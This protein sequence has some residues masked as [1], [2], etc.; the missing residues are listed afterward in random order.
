MFIIFNKLYLI[1]PISLLPRCFSPLIPTL[2]WELKVKLKV[3]YSRIPTYVYVWELKEKN[4]APIIKW[5]ILS[6]VYGN[7]KQNICNLCLTEKLWIINFIYDKNYLNKKSESISKC[8]H[9]CLMIAEAWN[10][11]LH[12]NS[13]IYILPR[14]NYHY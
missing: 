7:P 12:N 2:V 3:N 9:L 13:L 11:K 10:F 14:I 4:I 8:R 6:K 1:F 5:E